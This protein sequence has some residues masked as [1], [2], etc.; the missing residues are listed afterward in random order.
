MRRVVLLVAAASLASCGSS[1]TCDASTCATG[2]CLGGACHT[3]F[4][5]LTCSSGGAACVA[6]DTSVERCHPGTRSCAPYVTVTIDYTLLTTVNCVT[7]G[8]CH[9]ETHVFASD[10]PALATDERASTCTQVLVRP[11]TATAPATYAWSACAYCG[12]N[13][14][15]LTP[16][17]ATVTAC[18]FVLP[19][20]W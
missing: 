4:S 18:G 3:E 20:S 12:S 10:Y 2:C 6:C 5:D 14:C 15:C 13:A 19:G 1:S 7:A 8:P 9:A 16:W 17:G 11:S